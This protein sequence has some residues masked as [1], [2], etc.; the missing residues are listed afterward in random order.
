MKPGARIQRGVTM[1]NGYRLLYRPEHPRAMRSRGYNGW[2]YEHIFVMEQE[3]GRPLTE[4]E[5]IHHLDGDKANNSTN[6]LIVLS[7]SHH[8]RLHSWMSGNT[9]QKCPEENRK[10][11]ANPKSVRKRRAPTYCVSC[12]IVLRSDAKKYCQSCFAQH[13]RKVAD[14]PAPEEILAM[15][16]EHGYVW[17]GKKYG[18]SD[19]AVRKWVRAAGMA[20]PSRAAMR[21]AEGV[22]TTGNDQHEPP[23]PETDN[24]VGDDIVLP[25]GESSGR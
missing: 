3:L 12:G 11:S 13:R 5:C 19:N 23:A 17:V 18:V 1:L 15:A 16:K 10:N 2:I 21:R 25:P 4:N 14:R 22:E 6:N 8:S 24:A 7:L 9:G 20:T